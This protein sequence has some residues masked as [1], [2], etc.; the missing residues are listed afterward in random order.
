MTDT[1]PSMMRAL[2]LHH[3]GEPADVLRLK[4]APVPS[5]GPSQIR[6]RVHACALNPAT[7]LPAAC[8][9]SAPRSSPLAHLPLEAWREALDLAFGN[10]AR[11]KVVLLPGGA[12]TGL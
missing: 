10:R 11:G 7:P 8:V 5:P 4:D 1:V 12:E 9:T 2:R 3:Y 6:V